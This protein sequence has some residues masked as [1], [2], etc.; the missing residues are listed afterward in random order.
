MEGR[1]SSLRQCSLQQAVGLA[2]AWDGQPGD[3]TK[4][5]AVCVLGKA[6]KVQSVAAESQHT[7]VSR[8]TAARLSF[9]LAFFSLLTVDTH[10]VVMDFNMLQ[11]ES[12]ISGQS[13]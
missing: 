2:A 12:A 6:Q 10:P 7:S 11:Y 8:L 5:P 13:Y 3:A 1:S 9:W 4:S